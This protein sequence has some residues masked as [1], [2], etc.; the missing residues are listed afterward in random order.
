MSGRD[1]GERDEASGA[2]EWYR[3]WFG[4]EYL[5]L[6]PHRDREEAECAVDLFLEEGG[7]GPDDPVLDLGCGAGRHLRALRDRGLSPVGLDLSRPLLDRARREL[8]A[9]VPLVRADMRRIPFRGGT[10]AA[11]ASFFTS[12]GYF[13]TRSEDL[14]TLDEMKRVL[15]P[16]GRYLIDFLNAEQVRRELVPEEEETVRGRVVRQTRRIRD[17]QVVKRIEIEPEGAGE[18]AEVFHERVRLYE[19]EELVRMLRD[20]GLRPDG[21]FGDYAGGDHGRE[22]PRLIV[23]GHAA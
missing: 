6:Y 21:R 3:R 1:G 10:F 22:S 9:G 14:R 2:E 18:E 17:G 8:G 20:A 7:L 19:P 5:A 12:F 4:P 23:V 11:V 16:G 13:S 15:R